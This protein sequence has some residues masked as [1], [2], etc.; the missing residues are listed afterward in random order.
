MT[1]HIQ[2]FNID[3][4][5]SGLGFYNG[6]TPSDEGSLVGFGDYA[7]AIARAEKAESEVARLQAKLKAADEL[8]ESV[9]SVSRSAYG[10]D[11]LYKTTFH[12]DV[13]ESLNE[14]LCAY[15]AALTDRE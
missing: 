3:P 4:N 7:A 9:E 14:A 8:V 2:R 1:D 6:L 15:R 5:H 12:R 11:R 13:H 10:Y